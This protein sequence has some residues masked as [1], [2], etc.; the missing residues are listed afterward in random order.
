[1]RHFSLLVPTRERT[2][3]LRQYLDSIKQTAIFKQRLHVLIGYD[4]DDQETID[5]IPT[6]QGRYDFDIKWF[7]RG[8]SHFLNQ[9]YYNW[10]ATQAPW[11]ESDYFFINADDIRF[12][13]MEW[14]KIIESKVE[15]YCNNKPDRLIGVGVKDNTP[16]PKPSLPQFPCF[17][18]VTRETFKHFNFI[19]HPFIPTWGADYLFYL[20]YEGANRYLAIDDRVYMH[21]IGVHTHTAPKD[22]TA[23]QIEKTFNQLKMNPKHNVDLHRDTTIPQQVQAFRQHLKRISQ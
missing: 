7:K 16:K 14:D 11:E 5:F 10:L 3:S 15:M 4:E 22:A 6:T 2:S 23:I 13:V 17:P 9:D 21:H 8:R 20:L 12:V 19:L 18:L 1:M